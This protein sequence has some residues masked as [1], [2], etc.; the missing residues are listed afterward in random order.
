[1]RGKHD[2]LQ[3]TVSVLV[4]EI[5]ALK[6]MSIQSEATKMEPSN[7]PIAGP[8]V[9]SRPHEVATTEILLNTMYPEHVRRPFLYGIK[10]R[11]DFPSLLYRER[12]LRIDVDLISLA[13][14]EKVNNINKITM[15]IAIYSS[16]V[17]PKLIALNTSGN[18][19]FKGLTEND[20]AHGEVSFSRFQINEVTSHFRNGWVFLVMYPKFQPNAKV[21]A[22]GFMENQNATPGSF[23]VDPALIKP[24]IIEKV[25][26]KAKKRSTGNCDASKTQKL[27]D[28]ELS[29]Q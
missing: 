25:T 12:N 2:T 9:C 7:M 3:Q 5:M 6:T 18:K 13:T 1:M 17:P 24:L 21:S 19:V 23:V 20:M 26:V 10:P 28:E 15:G 8:E 16:E 14:G 11:K 29:P 22:G 27:E 4:R